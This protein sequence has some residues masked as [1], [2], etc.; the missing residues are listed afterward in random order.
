MALTDSRIRNAKSKAQAY[1]LSDGGGMYLLVTPNGARYWRLDYRFAGKRRTLALGVYP[2]V[3]LSNARA[4]REDARACLAKGTDP[5][6]VKKQIKRAAKYANENTFEGIAREWIENQ[7]TRLAPRYRALLL[8]RLEADI[9]PQIGARPVS[10]IDAPELLD[11]LKKVEQRGVIETARRLRQTSGQVFR[12]AIATGRAKHDPSADLRGAL[13]SPGR[14]RGHKAMPPKAR[15]LYVDGEMPAAAMQERIAQVTL[16]LARKPHARVIP[17]CYAGFARNADPDLASTRGQELLEPL[18]DGVELLVLDNLSTLCRSGR[19]NEADGWIP[20][21]TWLL[22]LRRRGISVLLVHHG[23]KGGAQRGTSKREDVLDTVINLRRPSD[24]DPTQGARFQVH[25]EK[26]RGITGDA[27][28]PFEAQLET[29][30][31]VA[32]WTMKDMND[33]RWCKSASLSILG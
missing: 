30:D 33:T 17:D 23:G 26:A 12:Y 11:T 19:E 4:R 29:R 3:T 24:Y 14:K 31:G 10:E 15:S 20:M 32:C 18:L 13:R 27:A 8:A 9:F 25:L 28:K 7:R 1:K 2:T 6:V 16:S 5:S 22:S 21:Q